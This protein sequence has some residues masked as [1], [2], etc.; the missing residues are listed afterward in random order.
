MRSSFGSLCA[1]L[2]LGA[3]SL[4]FAGLAQ[5]QEQAQGQPRGEEPWFFTMYG[6]AAG[7]LNDPPIE[8]FD[9]G[10][11]T[12]FG[13]YRSLSPELAL[14]GRLRMGGLSDG[15]ELPQIPND[16]VGLDYGM[17]GA[18][19]R[20]RPFGGMMDHGR[21]ATGLYIDVGPGAALLEGEVVFAYEAALGY[22]FDTGEVAIGPSFRFTHFFDAGER[23]GGLNLL[24]WTGGLEVAFNDALV[25]PREQ[26]PQAVAPNAEL[27]DAPL[28]SDGDW[29]LDDHDSCPNE[30]EVWNGHDDADGCPDEGTGEFENDALVVDE[31]VFFDY[32]SAELRATGFAQ[33]DAVVAH[34]QSHGER[35]EYLIIVGH[36]DARGPEDH[37][38]ELSRRRAESVIAYLVDRGVPRDSLRVEARG[39]SEPAVAQPED[40]YGHQVN[41]RVEFRLSW[42]EGMRPEGSEPVASPTMPEVVDEA[43]LAVQERERR[44]ARR[45]ARRARRSAEPVVAQAEPAPPSEVPS[46]DGR[47]ATLER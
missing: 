44:H 26:E 41:R 37:N 35:L 20:I 27:A 12:S 9:I 31:R 18:A 40:E 8:L 38:T 19:L 36:A 25:M 46:A 1:V 21:R 39:E 15:E 30:A 14:G 16:P 4:S 10:A 29:F 17:V 13:V 3:S 28:D 11:D 2:T 6:G 7:A 42:R 5:A 45:M 47:H 24:T 34:W 32:D 43:P 22:I 33:L 23:F